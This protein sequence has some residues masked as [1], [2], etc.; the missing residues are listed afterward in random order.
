MNM[1]YF[2]ETR[3]IYY[4]KAL[5]K[6]LLSVQIY[7]SRHRIYRHFIHP[8][9]QSSFSSS[10]ASVSVFGFGGGG[11]IA[12][13][14]SITFGGLSTGGKDCCSLLPE[15]P[16]RRSASLLCRSAIKSPP[17]GACETDLAEAYH[18]KI[19]HEY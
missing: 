8:Q 13:I 3:N 14:R 10:L 19:K 12:E 18:M 4:T 16:L 5:L 9:S 7:V 6:F 15:I 1:F 11:I 17:G 2:A